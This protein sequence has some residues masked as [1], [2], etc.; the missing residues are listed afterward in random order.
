[1]QKDRKSTEISDYLLLKTKLPNKS[2]RDISCKIFYLK[3]Q[4]FKKLES[5]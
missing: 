5:R 3:V 1:M 4:L 2:I